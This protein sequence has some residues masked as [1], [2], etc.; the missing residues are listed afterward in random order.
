[1]K[2]I[3]R[4]IIKTVGYI[5]AFLAV[6]AIAGLTLPYI[7]VNK[8]VDYK[9]PNDVTIYLKLSV[10]LKAALHLSSSAIH[11][12]F[13]NSVDTTEEKCV[14][15]DISKEDYKKLSDYIKNSFDVD[16]NGH[17]IHIPSSN[18]GYGDGDAFYE[19]KGSYSLFYTCNT[20]TNNA[21]KAAHQKAALWTLL[22]KGIFYQYKK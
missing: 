15:L 9:A 16:A 8:N 3:L 19:A 14:A 12:T 18:D 13:Y 6:Y 22:D 5:I 2:K 4:I 7:P 10:A 21:L 20:W 1:M 11:A 17:S